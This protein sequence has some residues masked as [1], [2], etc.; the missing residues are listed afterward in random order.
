MTMDTR[1]TRIHSATENTTMMITT[2]PMNDY[3]TEEERG[4]IAAVNDHECRAAAEG[5]FAQSDN[6][7]TKG[8]SN[9]GNDRNHTRDNRNGRQQYS[10]F[11]ACGVL[12]HSVHYGYKRC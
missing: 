3:A 7:R 11:A 1:Q 12:T 9:F 2:T 10:P 6:R 5:T 8:D 4:L